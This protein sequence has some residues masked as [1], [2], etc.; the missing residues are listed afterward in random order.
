MKPVSGTAL[1]GLLEAVRTRVPDTG[2]VHRTDETLDSDPGSY[3]L[4]L[5]LRSPLLVRIG[6]R[7]S[8]LPSGLYVYSGSAKGLGGLKARLGRHLR[9]NGQLRWHIDQITAH[10]DD[11]AGLAFRSLTECD[12]TARL[13]ECSSFCVPVP[14][15]GSSDCSTCSSHL[16]R[17]QASPED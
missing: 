9:G 14:G 6:K 15:F 2:I 11:R 12:L 13:L 17:F 1:D 16:I 4:L 10:A 5:R 7:E 8:R 3:L